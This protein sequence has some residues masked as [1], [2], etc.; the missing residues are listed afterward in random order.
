MTQVTF[1]EWLFAFSKLYYCDKKVFDK[2]LS[3]YYDAVEKRRTFTEAMIEN[4]M[5]PK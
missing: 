4:D 1:E 3:D 5:G 2:F